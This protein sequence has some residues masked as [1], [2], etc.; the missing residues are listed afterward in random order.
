MDIVLS[1]HAQQRALQWNVSHDEILFIVENAHRMHNAGVIFCQLQRRSLPHNLPGNAEYW[2][3]V[4]TTVL[5]CSR[6][7][8][9]VVTLYRGPKAFHD[10]RKKSKYCLHMMAQ[11]PCCGVL[12]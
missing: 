2:R 5:L 12:H 8:S 1:S 7:R 10:D 11:C 9:G 4:G 3:L 6:C